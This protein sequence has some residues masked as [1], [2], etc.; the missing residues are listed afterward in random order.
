MT[1]LSSDRLDATQCS[2]NGYRCLSDEP[3]GLGFGLDPVDVEWVVR[4]IL[5]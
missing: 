4:S 5:T 3:G 1:C 2:E